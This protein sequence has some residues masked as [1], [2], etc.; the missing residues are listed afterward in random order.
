VKSIPGRAQVDRAL[1]GASREVKNATRRINQQASK[2]MAR[3]DYEGAQH[4]LELARGVQDFQSQVEE[5]RG[6]WKALRASLREGGS[7]K[8]E[9]T[10]VWKLY[11]PILR[12]LMANGD[13]M[14]WKTIEDALQAGQA[15]VASHR[16]PSSWWPGE[17]RLHREARRVRVAD[18]RSREEGC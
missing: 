4:M 7:T 9:T 18:Y 6:R 11:T 1:K 17:G 12:T 15:Q 3:G 2:L 5:L 13:T 8:A 10:P 14:T 16:T